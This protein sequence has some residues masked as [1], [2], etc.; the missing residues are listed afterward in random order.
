MREYPD[1]EKLD[2]SKT[3]LT[4]WDSGAGDEGFAET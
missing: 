1:I 2:T 3:L 4:F